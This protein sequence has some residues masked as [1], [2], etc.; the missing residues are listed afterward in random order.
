MGISLG[1]CFGVAI[2]ML[3][4]TIINNIP[5]C[6]C[7]GI[8]IG[9]C[10]GVVVGSSIKKKKIIKNSINILEREIYMNK[11]ISML[12]SIVVYIISF[13]LIMIY[14][15]ID[16][17]K[18]IVLSPLEKVVI[19]ITSCVFMY[20]GGISASKNISDKNKDKLLKINLIVWLILYIVLLLN[21]TLF[22]GY[23]HRD[24]FSMY[25]W[26]SEMFNS[27]INNSFNIIPFNTIVS[28]IK[29]YISGNTAFYIFMY[30]IIGN[31]VALMPFAF[32]LP[33]I[34]KSQEK[35]KVF[36][37]TVIGIVVCIE[38]LQFITLSGSCDIDDVILNVGGACIMYGVLSI[39]PIKKFIKKIFLLN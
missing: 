36:L 30:N 7:F 34:F 5:I 11:K 32:F 2:G 37:L 26:N 15:I 16:F 10:I 19:L 1:M 12:I 14:Y 28:Y 20:I 4:G 21:L 38:L 39:E 17:S 25:H 13:G 8:S 18:N 3:V 22:D 27:Y 31:I 35:F 29:S 23:F 33:L 9:M 24:R 6:M